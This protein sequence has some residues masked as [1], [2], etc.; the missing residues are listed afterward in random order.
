MS[1]PTPPPDLDPAIT[2]RGRL[3]HGPTLPGQGIRTPRQTPL[4]PAEI[5]ETVAII[6]RRHGWPG[7]SLHTRHA[8]THGLTLPDAQTL[9]RSTAH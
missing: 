3:I 6:A 9:A 5:D 4:S 8:T 2:T 7:W 1:I